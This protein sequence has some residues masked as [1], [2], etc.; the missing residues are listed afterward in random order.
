MSKE[1]KYNEEIIKRHGKEGLKAREV[2]QEK[3]EKLLEDLYGE[4]VCYVLAVATKTGDNSLTLE[5]YAN[6]ENKGQKEVVNLLKKTIDSEPGA[7]HES[8][9]E[10]GWNG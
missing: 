10:V 1:G 4:D 2:M 9:P 5:S 6:M 7:I 3:I 8:G